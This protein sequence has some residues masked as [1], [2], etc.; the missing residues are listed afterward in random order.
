MN[1]ITLHKVNPILLFSYV[2]FILTFL[3][4][5][6]SSYTTDQST[7]LIVGG[8]LIV[9]VNS[10]IFEVLHDSVNFLIPAI[11]LFFV[12]NSLTQE[13]SSYS[14]QNFIIS[15]SLS[16]LFIMIATYLSTC[17]L[18]ID[19][20]LLTKKYKF[21]V[22]CLTFFLIFLSLLNDSTIKTILFF[23]IALVIA[24]PAIV[25]MKTHYKN[26][27]YQAAFCNFL[28]IILFTLTMNLLK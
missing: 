24:Y 23:N 17:N 28:S 14:I 7:M 22:A 27:I 16:Y 19:Q 6:F 11:C 8:A 3:G 13:L 5:I 25:L 20:T 4:G 10:K 12:G 15:F 9:Y 26:E 1:T 2:G 18:K 21:I